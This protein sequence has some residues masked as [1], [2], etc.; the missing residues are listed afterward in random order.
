MCMTCQC[1]IYHFKKPLARPSDWLTTAANGAKV[2]KKLTMLLRVVI[3]KLREIFYPGASQLMPRS[4]NGEFIANISICLQYG[5]VFM[6]V[7][8]Q[9]TVSSF[10]FSL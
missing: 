7:D 6:C 5:V 2:K 8:K 10:R 9:L 4:Q 3:G 1:H